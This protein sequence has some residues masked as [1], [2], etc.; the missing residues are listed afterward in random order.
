VSVGGWDIGGVNLKAVR[1]AGGTVAAV[2]SRPFE[3]QRAPEELVP[4]LREL[5]RDLGLEGSDPQAVTMTAELS[6]LF[7]TKREGVAFVLDAVAAAF[8]EPLVHVLQVEGPFLPVAR[9]RATPLAVA[10]A[11]WSATARLVGSHWPDALLIDVG[12]T[13]TDIIPIVAGQPAAI[14]RTDP[15]RLRSGELLYSGAVRTPV[16][17][18]ASVVCV[19]GQASGVSAEGFALAGD[20]HLWRGDLAP[21]DYCITPPDGRPATRSHA[22][23]R[24]ARV[25]CADRDMLSDAGISGI[26]DSLAEAQ[27]ARMAASIATVR[28]RHP[29]LPHAVVTGLG[30]FLAARAAARAGLA[31][32]SLAESLGRDAARTAPAAAAALLLERS[33][34]PGGEAP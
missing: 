4:L 30:E 5:A 31:V 33:L 14:G 1:V 17:A 7:R 20:V 6:Q 8:H 29:A 24:L 22:G 23:E 2:R 18:I 9:A 19:D 10:A 28:R 34:R 3:L 21:D 12:S 32:V 16:E 11:N 26:A 15:E 27:I 13:T 25:I